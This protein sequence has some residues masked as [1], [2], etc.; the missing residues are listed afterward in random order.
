M[1]RES[2]FSVLL[3]LL[4]GCIP[5]VYGQNYCGVDFADAV[6]RC[7][8][9][10]PNGVDSECPSGERCYA[11]TGCSPSTAPPNTGTSPAELIGYYELTWTD[12][13][14]QSNANTAIA[15]SG[16]IDVSR[17]KSE[18]DAKFSSLFGT[19]YISF[20]GGNENGR[21]SSSAI[22][23]IN[24]AIQDGTLQS[25]DGIC[26]D[27]EVGDSGLSDNLVNSFR[28]ARGNGFKVL[29]TV[30]HSAP[31]GFSDK[32]QVMDTVLSSSDVDYVSPQLYTTGREQQN[33]YAT[34][35]YDWSNFANRSPK[36]V[37]SITRADQYNDAVSTFQGYGVSLVGYI[38]WIAP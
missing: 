16:W 3:L 23:G 25:Y 5:I 14:P 9:P 33:D 12:S 37:V 34:D 10:C 31:Y 8:T 38:L 18:S 27:I 36:I 35:G 15:F 30:S 13:T 2:S 1:I 28:I 17:A 6:N 20:G 21:W 4:I 24:N 29:V 22:D 32:A 7:S 19:K 11:D 26:Y